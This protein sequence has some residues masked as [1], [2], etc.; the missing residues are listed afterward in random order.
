MSS[1]LR[2]A[3]PRNPNVPIKALALLRQSKWR[4]DIANE[5]LVKG[6]V[7]IEELAKQN[8]DLRYRSLLV[9]NNL[10][11][12]DFLQSISFKKVQKVDPETLYYIAYQSRPLL[13]GPTGNP[14]EVLR[15]SLLSSTDVGN[16]LM[17]ATLAR[18][19]ETIPPTA[20]LLLC[21]D[22]VIFP[23]NVGTL[24][25]TASGLGGIDGLIATSQTCDLYGWKVLE[26]SRGYGF[27]I[28]SKRITSTKEIVKTVTDLNLLPIVGHASE[29][30]SPQEV[31][32]SQ[33]RGAL[34]V[35][36]NEKHGPSQ[37][38]LDVCVRVRIP[39]NKTAMNSLN[40][41]V[42]GAL[43]IQSIKESMRILD[44]QLSEIR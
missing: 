25:R 21:L 37:D 36:G 41:S 13:S 34:I 9:P 30:I 24:I 1:V 26:A 27:N 35:V 33:H 44:S 39:I 43:L 11:N 6:R 38:L 18:P 20:R 4:R 16:S 42:A 7:Q 19:T 17:I 8:P 29:G 22:G 15:R 14:D 40:V 12:Y 31:D 23:Q 2:K 3:L 10:E 28:P 32:F 5:V